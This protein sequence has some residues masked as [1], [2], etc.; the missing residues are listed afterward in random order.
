MT[1]KISCPY[2]KAAFRER[3]APKIQCPKCGN[4]IL[5]RKGSP[6]TQ[7]EAGIEDWVKRV[8]YLGVTVSYF[9]EQWKAAR[10]ELGQSPELNDVAWRILNNLLLTRRRDKSAVYLE[11]AQIAR[12]E[13]KNPNPYLIEVNREILHSFQADPAVSRVTV[14]HVRD[15]LVCPDC[16]ALEDRE[17]T[18]QEA[19]ANP[20]IPNA[21]TSAA[22]CRCY[23]RPIKDFP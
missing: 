14:H 4:T 1:E 21:C 2:C 9:R 12:A 8:E 3:P 19:L 15:R 5:I 18:I 10:K 16:L 20:P 13:G 22:G 7:E 6:L 11:M 17:W 23:Y